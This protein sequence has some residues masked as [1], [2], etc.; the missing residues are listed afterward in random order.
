MHGARLGGGQLS[1]RLG[2]DEWQKFYQCHRLGER[3]EPPRAMEPF[4]T[5]NCNNVQTRPTHPFQTSLLHTL[6]PVLHA[7]MATA[8]AEHPPLLLP[9]PFPMIS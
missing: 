3:S 1:G 6:P 9:V 4:K 8:P 7:A 5:T 2:K